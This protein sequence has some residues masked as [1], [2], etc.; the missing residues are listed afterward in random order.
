MSSDML[1][2]QSAKKIEQTVTELELMTKW[3]PDECWFSG[4][5]ATYTIYLAACLLWLSTFFW[6]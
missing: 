2:F 4:T 1:A 6:N 5:K 3:R